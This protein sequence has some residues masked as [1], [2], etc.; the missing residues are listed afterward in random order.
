MQTSANIYTYHI[1][2]Y[3]YQ[4]INIT[5]IYMRRLVW[6]S[7][8]GSSNVKMELLAAPKLQISQGNLKIN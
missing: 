7:T 2:I 1:Y 3:I 5:D 4:N 8:N 6:G